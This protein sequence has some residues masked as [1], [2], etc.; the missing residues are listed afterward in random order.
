MSLLQ[1]IL[2]RY[3]FDILLI[4]FK[5]AANLIYPLPVKQV[6]DLQNTPIIPL[7]YTIPENV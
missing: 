4:V 1:K 7:V 5:I 3:Y 2:C 6:S